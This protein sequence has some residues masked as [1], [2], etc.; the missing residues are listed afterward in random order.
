MDGLSRVSSFA[1]CTFRQYRSALT[2]QSRF[3]GLAPL[4]QNPKS[5]HASCAVQ[6]LWRQLRGLIIYLTASHST[7]WM[8]LVIGISAESSAEF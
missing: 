8:S 1:S 6:L 3:R 7:T 5:W 2:A 4:C